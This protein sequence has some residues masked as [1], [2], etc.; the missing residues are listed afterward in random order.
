[1]KIKNLNNY[2]YID[3]CCN[4]SL[5]KNL[6]ATIDEAISHLVLPIIVSCDKHGNELSKQLGHQ[7][8]ITLGIHP[9]D[10]RNSSCNY[11][12]RNLYNGENNC[13]AIGECGLDFNRMYSPKEQQIDIFKE[14]V[15][16]AK[17]YNMP[18]ILHERDAKEKFLEIIRKYNYTNG[19]VHCF[20]GDKETVKEYLDLGFYIGITGWICDERRNQEL[21]EAV[22]E[23]PLD[24]LLVETDSP[25]LLP[26]KYGVKG[27][28]K[29]E[30][31][32]YVVKELSLI[33]RIDEEELRKKV[34]ENT[35]KL[36][37]LK[38]E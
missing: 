18:L 23:I 20:T 15:Q 3:I 12:T 16:L 29:P 7:I 10:S 5:G 35:T 28:N 27:K 2:K 37:G 6:Q 26:K 25:Y 22:K 13:I 38:E 17:K 4:A 14:Q 1:M 32:R 31:V 9:H 30:N 33:L 8:P 21:K 19:V 11:I 24:K 36:F 34:F